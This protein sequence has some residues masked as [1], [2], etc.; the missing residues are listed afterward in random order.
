[1]SAA[2]RKHPLLRLEL[3]QTM[4]GTALE[5]VRE[6]R[7]DA[8]FYFGDAPGAPL[9]ALPL[10]QLIYRVAAPAAWAPRVR[11]ARW[12][13]VAG[14]PW[15]RTPTLST[16]TRLVSKLFA[17][18]GLPPPQAAVLA[19]DETVITSLVVA[20]LGVALV[21]DEVARARAAE[22]ELVVWP[23]AAI[24]TTLWFVTVAAR[25]EEPA[26]AALLDLVRDAWHL[27]AAPLMV[28]PPA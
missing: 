27:Q 18:H 4:S 25:A 12:H 8:S 20:G 23:H 24:E 10:R 17:A 6:G 14:L 19:D 22:G 7:L 3:H 15:I 26:L 28:G 2:V 21:R 16:H 5:S 11:E 13:E 9:A 1:M